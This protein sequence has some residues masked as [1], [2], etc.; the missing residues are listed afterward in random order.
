MNRRLAFIAAALTA[1]LELQPGTALAQA[2]TP[3]PRPPAP[4]A[5]WGKTGAPEDARF[6]LVFDFAALPGSTSYGD[7]RTPT[8]YAEPSRIATS[9]DA[10]TGIG[11]GA[12]LQVGLYRGLGL[13]AG[14]SHTSRDATGTLDVSRPHPLYLNRPRTASAD[15]P[16][17]RYSEGA[18]DVDAAFA[19]TAGRLDWALFGGVSFFSVQAD[20]LDV[21]TFN[22][23]YPYDTLTILSTPSLAV[24]QNATGWNLGG[25]LDY[26]FG[27]QKR[28]G[29]GVTLRYSGASVKLEGTQAS[30]PATL[31][32]GG[33]S[34]G[35][36]LRVYF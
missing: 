17:S 3:P 6:R 31:D 33:F 27:Q 1:V 23:V 12:A 14:Y 21:P 15:L 25:R 10:G 29:A 32:V 13:L 11:G 22:E 26:R 8:A 20:L 16:G 5:A 35:G 36:G 34:V 19:R 4:G 30:T 24:K 28:F 2:T 9:Y 7:V 18:F